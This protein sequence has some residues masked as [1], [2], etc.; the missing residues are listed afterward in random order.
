MGMLD[1]DKVNVQYTPGGGAPQV[2]PNV[3]DAAS[4]DPATGGWYYDNPASPTKIILCGS[5][6][7]PIELDPAG[8]IDILL[9]CAT[10]HM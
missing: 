4:C 8:K 5:T 2:I 10:E 6:C 7:A 9:G 3:M 1:Y